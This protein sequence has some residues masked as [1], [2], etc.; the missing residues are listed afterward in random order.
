MAS[1]SLRGGCLCGATRYV[2]RGIPRVAAFCHCSMC[3]RSAGAPVTAWAMFDASAFELEKGTPR[4]YASSPEVKRRF[5]GDCGTQLTFEADFLPGLVD[6]T[7]GS[8][9]DPGALPPRMHIWDDSRLAWVQLADGL[10]RHR[11]LPP[12]S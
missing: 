12:Q 4:T 3:R 6:V 7:V 2:V 1:D 5:C 10:P 9:D 11:E 8:L